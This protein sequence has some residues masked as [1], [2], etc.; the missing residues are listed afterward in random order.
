MT[1]NSTGLCDFN[2]LDHFAILSWMDL[3]F[4]I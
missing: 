4:N 2:F 3:N 1:F